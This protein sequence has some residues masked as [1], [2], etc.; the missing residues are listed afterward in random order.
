MLGAVSQAAAPRKLG[1]SCLKN[2]PLCTRSLRGEFTAASLKLC[3]KTRAPLHGRFSRQIHR[4]LIRMF[5]RQDQSL[6]LHASTD[7]IGRSFDESEEDFAAM[8]VARLDIQT[9]KVKQVVDDY[10][11][12]KLVIPEFQ[13]E[14]VWKP[15][16]A[17]RLLDS[18]YRGFPISVLLLWTST[19]E[20]RARR[21]DPRPLRG[22]A[23][24]WLIDG[25]QR[26][27]TLSR[28]MSG[29]EGIEV[30]FNPDED[31]FRLANAATRRDNSWIRVSDLFDDESYRQIRRALPEGNKGEKREA[32]FERVRAIR[33]YEIPAVR[34]VDHSFDEAVEAFTRINT[35]GVKLK[36]EDIDSAR[37]AARHSGFIADEVSPFVDE[38]RRQGFE[39]L[40]VMHLFRA[41]AFVAMPDGRTRTPL[42]EL[43]KE[44]VA[45]AWSRT[46]R[47]T[48]QAIALVRNEFGLVNMD[49]LW[50]GALLVP[51][52]AIC[53][54]TNIRER[55][56]RGIAGWLAMAA[57]LHRYSAGAEA[58]LDQDLRAC[59]SDD[60]VGKL[61]TNLRRDVGGFGAIP[62]D[63]KGSLNDRG[64]LFAAYVACRHMGLRDLFSGSQ[65]ML[66]A[67]VDRHHILPRAQFPEKARPKADNVANIAFVNG[68]V[69]R[70]IGAASP[71]VYLAKIKTEI[72]ESQCI[73]IDKSLWR[74]D[75]ADDFWRARQKLLAQA[76]NQFLRKMMPAR[77]VDEA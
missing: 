44:E 73:P 23:V 39:R 25:Q 57:L 75:R 12:G 76:F 19:F 3:A 4:G 16:K 36:R 15:S 21:K 54:S 32:Q 38:L 62:A 6:Y 37:V 10:R 45:V 42:H 33:E 7:I 49:I 24:S 46:K 8:I 47:A 13:R 64:A 61:L 29:D 69:N 34:M 27:I 17:P 68:E 53:A 35:L 66:Q 63:F 71:D 28:L 74:I 48:E 70:A 77:R 50:S 1:R 2:H 14:Y 59:R 31:Q 51:V 67:R 11:R 26:V 56:P 40:N 43:S 30:V 58:A 9:L 60:P 41:C 72:L 20:A 65:M 18:I 52:I 55:D 22:S 5:S